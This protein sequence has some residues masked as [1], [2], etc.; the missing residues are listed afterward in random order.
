MSNGREEAIKKQ[1]DELDAIIKRNRGAFA[2]EYAEVLDGLQGLSPEDL[3]AISPGVSS[4]P[5]YESLKDA[6]RL[7][8]QKNLAAAELKARIEALGEKAVEI[9]KLVPGLAALFA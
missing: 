4:G 3:D 9:A 5:E 2:V 7:A 6:V 8:S 1:R